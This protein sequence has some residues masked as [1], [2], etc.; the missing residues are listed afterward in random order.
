MR[1]KMNRE[2]IVLGIIIYLLS[3]VAIALPLVT[4][5]PQD[6]TYHDQVVARGTSLTVPYTITNYT[7]ATLYE[8]T[9]TNLAKGV[10]SS[11]CPVLIPAGSC[12]LT[13]TIPATLTRE[14]RVI[15]SRFQVCVRKNEGC[16]LVSLANQLDITVVNNNTF[17]TITDMHVNIANTGDITYGQDSGVNLWNSAKGEISSLITTQAPKFILFSGDLPNHND[18]PHLQTNIAAVLTCLSGLPAISEHNIPVFY[19]FGNNDSLVNDYGPY[20]D[21]VSMHNLFYL[22]PAHSSPATKG[23]P[24]LN[25]NPDCSVSP[26]FACT[27]TTTSPMPPEHAA[28]MANVAT[29]DGYYSAY[30]LGSSV[31]L[32]LISLNSVIFSRDYLFYAY[33]PVTQLAAAQAEMNWLAAQLASAKANNEFVYIMMHVPVGKDAFY[34]GDSGDMWNDTLYIDNIPSTGDHLLFRDAFLALVTQY[35]STVRAVV[36]AHTHEDELRALYPSQTSMNMETLDVGIP[37]ITPN[38]FNN[39]GMQVYLY[40]KTFQLTEAKTYYTTPVPSGWRSYSFVNDYDCS[41]KSTMFS[42]VSTKILPQLPAWKLLPQPIPGN[43]YEMNYPVRNS[44]YNPSPFGSWLAILD[45]IQ[46]VPIN[47]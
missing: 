28:D 14:P 2:Q 27:Y 42:C 9:A 30:P 10:I 7:P 25:A 18:L 40:D 31:L 19:A 11:V 13:L 15:Q 21:V 41:K 22:D 5:T 43:P 6:Y 3:F 39:P 33:D 17:I 16:T 32:R 34:S 44:G 38:H 47:S 35:K 46:V 4:I 29:G 45:T 37:G 23:W 1:K 12:T 20:Y 26:N 8:V 24:T 36:S